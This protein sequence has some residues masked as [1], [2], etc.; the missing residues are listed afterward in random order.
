MP[1]ETTF[2][3]SH[4]NGLGWIDPGGWKVYVGLDLSDLGTKIAE[5]QAIIK[6]LDLQ[7]IRPV[8]V[9]VE[10]IDAPFFRTQ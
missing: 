1:Q 2:L 9:S 10:H 7:G 6:K 4:N 5:Y 8:M 3:Y